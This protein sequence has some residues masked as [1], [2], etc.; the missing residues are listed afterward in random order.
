[1]EPRVGGSWLK[2]GQ[3]AGQ[4]KKQLKGAGAEQGLSHEEKAEDLEAVV[5][6]Y[7]DN[8]ACGDDGKLDPPPQSV[9]CPSS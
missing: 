9:G 7:A 2:T 8:C 6:T 5:G 1:M 3:R 4:Q